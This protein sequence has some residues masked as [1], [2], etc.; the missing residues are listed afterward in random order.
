MHHQQQQQQQQQ[1]LR[2]RVE[3]AGDFYVD[4]KVLRL[5][6]VSIMFLQKCLVCNRSDGRNAIIERRASHC[7]TPSLSQ[8]QVAPQQ[9]AGSQSSLHH[10]DSYHPP[11]SLKS[12]GEPALP[13]AAAVY[14]PSSLNPP[15][16][17][18]SAPPGLDPTS[19]FEMLKAQLEVIAPCCASGRFFLAFL[20][21][22]LKNQA[23]IQEEERLLAL[24]LQQQQ[25]QQH[26]TFFA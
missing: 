22:L 20:C 7:L 23:Q 3:G 21:R 18:L 17:Q 2:D 10:P 24:S 1:S 25:Q 6:A 5:A 19:A 14:I 16:S 26:D 11:V 15:L 4:R 12:L 9:P 13:Q 8:P